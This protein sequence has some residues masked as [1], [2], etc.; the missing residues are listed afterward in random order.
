MRRNYSKKYCHKYC[1]YRKISTKLQI[2]FKLIKKNIITNNQENG[3]CQFPK[4]NRK[5]KDKN[6]FKSHNS[7]SNNIATFDCFTTFYN[8]G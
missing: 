4:N 8:D 6:L 1:H 2:F 7:S 5:S 3:N